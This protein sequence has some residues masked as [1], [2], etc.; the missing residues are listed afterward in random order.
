MLQRAS[1]HLTV[2]PAAHAAP[3]SLAAAGSASA[4]AALQTSLPSPRGA[5]Q[6]DRCAP[7]S[8]QSPDRT[9]RERLTRPRASAPPRTAR[10]GPS[11]CSVF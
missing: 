1:A 2:V 11:S 8:R 4:A 6:F 5:L 9:L 7:S 10:A 3:L